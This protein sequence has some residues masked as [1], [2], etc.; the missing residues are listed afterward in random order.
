[1]PATD[2][3]KAL[4]TKVV[5]EWLAGV[6][7][8]VWTVAGCCLVRE[9]LDAFNDP[10][11]PLT[12]EDWNNLNSMALSWVRAAIDD[13]EGTYRLLRSVAICKRFRKGSTP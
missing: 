3:Q 11:E 7:A 9:A 13:D 5:T 2:E 1:M 8:S 12:E 4:I 6:T 10:A